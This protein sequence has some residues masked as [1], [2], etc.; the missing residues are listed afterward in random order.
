MWRLTG[1][2]LRPAQEILLSVLQGGLALLESPVTGDNPLLLDH[3][4]R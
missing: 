1:P 4:C 3:S 2:P